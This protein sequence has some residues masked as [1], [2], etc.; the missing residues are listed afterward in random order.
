MGTNHKLKVSPHPVANRMP[1]CV[2]IA[3]AA[4]GA[5]PSAPIDP[6][7]I[8]TTDE[9]AARLKVSPRVIYGQTRVRSQN[10]IPHFRV[11]KVLRFNWSSV[12]EW[13]RGQKA[14]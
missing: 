6:S 1:G 14:A 9:L 5:L 3:E 7:Q 11:G 8:L 10:A 4:G 13:L 2:R 12:S